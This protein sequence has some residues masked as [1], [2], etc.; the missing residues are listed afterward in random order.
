MLPVQ[1]T[2]NTVYTVGP[3]HCYT[4]ELNGEL[5]LFD[6]GPPTAAAKQYITQHI[7]IKKLRHVIITHCHIDHY[8]LAQWLEQQSDATIYLPFRDYLRNSRHHES[9]GLMSALLA[10]FGFG[11]EVLDPFHHSMNNGDLFPP[12]PREAKI[13]EEDLPERLGLTAMSCAGHSQSD[14]VLMGKQWAITGDVLLQGIFQTPLLDVDL[15]TGERFRNYDAYCDSLIKLASLRDMQIL[16]G[17][18]NRIDGVD[19]CILFYINKL[20]ERVNKIKPVVRQK[21]VA[22]IVTKLFVVDRQNPFDFYFKASGIVFMRDFL[23]QPE[24]LKTAL[25]AIGLFAA[26]ADKFEKVVAY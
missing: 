15:L 19:S 6:T 22:E 12:L 26:V 14:M 1:H 17:H 25:V 24:R 13:I 7:D 11:A 18:Q 21:T 9:L 23:G 10:Q 2:I 20:L 4:A 5:V 3:V 16:P 8:G